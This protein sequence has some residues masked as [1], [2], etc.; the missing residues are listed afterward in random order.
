MTLITSEMWNEDKFDGTSCCC[1]SDFT[2]EK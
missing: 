1:H 2:I